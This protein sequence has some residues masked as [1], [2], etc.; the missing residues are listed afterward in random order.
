MHA[1]KHRGTMTKIFMLLF[2]IH[3]SQK[4]FEAF[5]SRKGIAVA[6]L[7]FRLDGDRVTGEQTPKMLEL[8]E[9]DQIDVNL[10]MVRFFST[11]FVE[12][13]NYSD[14]IALS[15]GLHFSYFPPKLTHRLEVLKYRA[16]HARMR[17]DHE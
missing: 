15:F 8:E 12:V 3:I 13:Y 6:S 16:A 10:Q 1:A 14:Y 11:C 7:N 2:D 9:N 5:A 17:S 4:I